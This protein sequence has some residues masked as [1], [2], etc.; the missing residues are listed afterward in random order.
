LA[1]LPNPNIAVDGLNAER[2]KA[3]GIMDAECVGC[4]IAGLNVASNTSILAL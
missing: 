4:Q 1:N 3:D 2:C